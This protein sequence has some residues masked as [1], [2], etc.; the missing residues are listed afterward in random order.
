M[1]Q[2]IPPRHPWKALV[3]ATAILVAATAAHAGG[4]DPEVAR[5]NVTG[6]LPLR[7]AC[8]SVDADLD[9]ALTSAWD[10]ADKPSAIAVTFKVQGQHVYDVAPQSDSAATFHQIRR[11][12][13]G[14]R[15]DGGDDAAHSVRFVVRF[16]DV[17]HDSRVA[18]IDDAATVDEPAGR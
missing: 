14:L 12:M 17:G 13:H 16:V 15:C 7:E 18:M 10:A 5:V 8:S 4:S 2:P 6:Q 9:G 11:A 3:A 1:N